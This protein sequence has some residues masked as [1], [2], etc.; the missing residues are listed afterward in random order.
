MLE[1][2]ADFFFFFRYFISEST[3]SAFVRLIKKRLFAWVSQI[4]RGFTNLYSTFSAIEL[5]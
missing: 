3:S 1:G 4:V 2:P 5:K